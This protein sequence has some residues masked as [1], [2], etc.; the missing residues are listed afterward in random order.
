MRRAPFNNKGPQGRGL[1]FGGRDV[2]GYQ[3]QQ[4]G[5]GAGG[6]GN[7]NNSNFNQSQQQQGQRM[8]Q[9]GQGQ[10]KQYDDGYQQQ[11]LHGQGN[12]QGQAMGMGMGQQYQGQSGYQHQGGNQHQQSY[13]RQQAPQQQQGQ[14][15][16]VPRYAPQG[17]QVGPNPQYGQQGTSY[18][19]MVSPQGHTPSAAPNVMAAQ[20]GYYDNSY[21]MVYSA[22]G[23]APASGMDAITGQMAHMGV[24][25]SHG[26][27]RNQYSA[28]RSS[29]GAVSYVPGAVAGA[30]AVPRMASQAS[31]YQQAYMAVP[32]TGPS[33]HYEQGGYTGSQGQGH[34]TLS[35]GQNQSS[36]YGGGGRYG[37]TGRGGGGGGVMGGRALNVDARPF[38]AYAGAQGQG[39]GGRDYSNQGQGHIADHAGHQGGAMGSANNN[40]TQQHSQQQQ[41]SQGQATQ[42]PYSATGEPKASN[43]H[44]LHSAQNNAY[45]TS[46]TP[47]GAGPGVGVVMGGNSNSGGIGQ[48]QG[49]GAGFESQSPVSSNSNS[50]SSSVLDTNQ[51]KST[52]ASTSA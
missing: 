39:Q 44:S 36:N 25:Q 38:N 15:S 34:G 48:S 2:R 45:A 17:T 27:Q 19:T 43:G 10:Y 32:P 47:G 35:Y 20:G 21:G 26:H 3:P 29:E 51:H 40:Y 5:Y 4:G 13:M 22:P 33:S 41:H 46:L 37:N 6:Y 23:G 50:N 49:A 7:S 8:A 30:E 14:Q 28:D 11:Q 12:G 9:Q 24:T 18:G 16:N 1:S 52:D 42:I 31:A